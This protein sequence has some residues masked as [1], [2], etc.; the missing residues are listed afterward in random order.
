M[1]RLIIIFMLVLTG[2]GSIVRQ[3]G[4]HNQADHFHKT[5]DL[6]MKVHV[7]GNRNQFPVSQ[8]RRQAHPKAVGWAYHNEIWVLGYRL[9]NGKIWVYQEPLGHEFGHIL[10]NHDWEIENPDTQTNFIILR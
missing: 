2:C 1:K 3:S 6:H 10:N 8:A 5:V 9:P 4:H 7:V